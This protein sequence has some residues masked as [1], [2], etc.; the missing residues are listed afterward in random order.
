MAG[1]TCKEFRQKMYG[2]FYEYIKTMGIDPDRFS[3][4]AWETFM[5]DR[6]YERYQKDDEFAVQMHSIPDNVLEE[7][8]KQ[9]KAKQSKIV[10]PTGEQVDIIGKAKEH[11]KQ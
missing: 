4:D 5:L 9:R 3:W 7:I 10:P 2:H 1:L 11:I 6:L 8:L